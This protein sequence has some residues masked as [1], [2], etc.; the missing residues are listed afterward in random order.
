MHTK[1]PADFSNTSGR[2][3]IADVC[4]YVRLDVMGKVDLAY[5]LERERFVLP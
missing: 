4:L 2:G 5:G 3:G 1:K